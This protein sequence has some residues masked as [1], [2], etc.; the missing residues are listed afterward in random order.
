MPGGQGD[1][2]SWSAPLGDL[3]FALALAGD[4]GREVWVGG[5][6]FRPG[7]VGDREAAFIVPS[8]VAVRGGFAGFETHP[9]QRTPGQTPTVL[10]G[11]LA[12]NDP[13]GPP[14]DNAF[15]VVRIGRDRGSSLAELDGLTIEGGV[16][17]DD[18]PVWAGPGGGVAVVGGLATLRNC[19][20]QNN[21]GVAGGG[22]HVDGAR[23]LIVQCVVAGNSAIT[24]G[25]GLSVRGS[26][27]VQVVATEFD[28]NAARDGGAIGLSP[29]AGQVGLLNVLVHACVALGDGGGVFLNGGH[30]DAAFVTV[31]ENTAIG[32][33]GGIC[34]G[35]ARGTM[36]ARATIVASNR[37][38][39]RLGEPIAQAWSAMGPA[40]LP[41]GSVQEID[42]IV[43]DPP[44]NRPPKPRI[45]GPVMLRVTRSV[46]LGWPGK[47]VASAGVRAF[48]VRGDDPNFVTTLDGR[49]SLQ[50]ESPAI[51]LATTADVPS[52]IFDLDADGDLA[53]RLPLDLAGSPRVAG[54]AAEAARSVGSRREARPDAGVYERRSSG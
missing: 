52:D 25:G 16:A 45:A 8:G 30:V 41:V 39:G 1:G 13:L 49:F 33:G 21:V 36:N 9:D 51:A 7:R 31:A 54:D 20:V 35:P 12:E 38:F 47:P 2:A 5:G 23:V 48:D 44:A 26:A 40:S 22:I 32:Q 53:E 37:A 34:F 46:I 15:Q 29:D 6:V 24:L 19:Q 18:M 11:D 50:F 10:S 28:R 17:D 3:A 27:D 43:A 4:A 42:A 14:G